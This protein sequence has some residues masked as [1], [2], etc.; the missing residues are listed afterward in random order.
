MVYC[1][2]NLCIFIICPPYLLN[3]L[4]PPFTKGCPPNRVSTT[5][6][7]TLNFHRPRCWN[8]K[9]SVGPP[10]LPT[11]HRSFQIISISINSNDRCNAQNRRSHNSISI[12]S[13]D[14][15]N[16]AQN[17]RCPQDKIPKKSGSQSRCMNSEH[18][19]IT[20]TKNAR[21]IS[22]AQNFEH[23][24]Q[25]W[26]CELNTLFRFTHLPCRTHACMLNLP[27]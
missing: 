13:S 1:F 25:R 3:G 2:G 15:Y 19:W 11:L 6:E 24:H 4:E 16:L 20:S 22:P 8:T 27:T 17:R 21:A 26:P 10:V 14:R 5:A 12:P 18:A 7:R 9:S 23:K